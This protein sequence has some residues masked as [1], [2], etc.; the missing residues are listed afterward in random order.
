M[1]ADMIDPRDIP[2]KCL[3]TGSESRALKHLA[4]ELRLSKSKVLL[5]AFLKFMR[6]H[7]DAEHMRERGLA[8]RP[9]L[10]QD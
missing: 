9:E 10:G 7:H 5:L 2:E 6:E 3:M 8:H 1:N 4:E